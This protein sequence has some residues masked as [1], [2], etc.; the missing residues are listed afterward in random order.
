MDYDLIQAAS[1]YRTHLR[2]PDESRPLCGKVFRGKVRQVGT[3]P[4]FA[5]NCPECR[6][7]AEN[8]DDKGSKR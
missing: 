7:V 5:A 2:A 4:A 1:D 6:K 3:V 8:R